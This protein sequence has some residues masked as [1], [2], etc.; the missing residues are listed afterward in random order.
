MHKGREA[1][2]VK[3]LRSIYN[4]T[5]TDWRI[6][7][8][9]DDDSCLEII[10]KWELENIRVFKQPQYGET[11]YNLYCNYLKEKVRSAWFMF[12]DSDDFLYNETSLE[13]MSKYLDES[14]GYDAVICQMTRTFG[15]AK[16]SNE[17]I[18]KREVHSGKI[19]LPCIVVRGYMKDKLFFDASS[20]ADYKYIKDIA[21]NY[22]VNFVKEVLVHSPKRM[23][24]K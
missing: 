11:Y 14:N 24:G 23:F 13:R 9:Y 6:V 22:N 12:L 16:P 21:D 20:N 10:K 1:L 5:S 19:G 2:F 18:E 7:C 8:S 17:L 4:Q 3:C 15:F